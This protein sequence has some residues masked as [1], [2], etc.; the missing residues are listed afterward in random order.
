LC[1]KFNLKTGRQ[2]YREIASTK[3]ISLGHEH[4]APGNRVAEK[5]GFILG[6]F[7]TVEGKTFVLKIQS[8]GLSQFYRKIASRKCL[9]GQM[10]FYDHV[11]VHGGWCA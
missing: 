11:W 1:L 5:E 2:F 7:K 4:L 10:S 3:N 6:L 8:G 9:S